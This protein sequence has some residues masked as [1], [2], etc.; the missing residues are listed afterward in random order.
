MEF[1]ES[2]LNHVHFPLPEVAKETCPICLRII[3]WDT[4]EQR[5]ICKCGLI[6]IFK[7]SDQFGIIT[8]GGDKS[9]D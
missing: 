9:N 8:F 1:Q 2:N 4:I 3:E 7:T 5:Y 6:D